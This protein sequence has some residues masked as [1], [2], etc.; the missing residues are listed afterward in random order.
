LMGVAVAVTGLGIMGSAVLMI[1]SLDNQ[2]W[3]KWL[4]SNQFG[5]IL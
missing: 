4:T 3:I 5:V 1:R 2:N